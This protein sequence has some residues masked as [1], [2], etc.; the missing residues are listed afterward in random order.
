MNTNAR[1]VVLFGLAR[2]VYTRIAAM[3]MFEKGVPY[4]L[5]EVEIFGPAGV[6]PEHLRRHPFGRIPVLQHGEFLLYETSAICRYVDEAFDGPPLQPT[7]AASRARMNQVVGLLDAYAYRPMVWDVF[8]QEVGRP[9]RGLPP[10]ESVVSAALPKVRTALG[11][12]SGLY[13]EGPFFGGVTPSLADLH[14]Y[15]MLALLAVAK[16]GTASLAAHPPLCAWLARMA[17]RTSARQTLSVYEQKSGTV[18]PDCSRPAGSRPSER[19]QP[20]SPTV[21]RQS[22]S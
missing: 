1:P 5:H 13:A 19:R 22:G 17:K 2:S 16:T 9:M 20:D 15:P 6:P 14:A 4:E 11:A 12:L 18:G 7:G 10:E 8:V 3:T 21:P